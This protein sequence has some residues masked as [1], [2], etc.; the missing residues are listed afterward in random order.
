M[1]AHRIVGE[2]VARA[3]VLVFAVALPV[4]PLLPR[5]LGNG[6]GTEVEA[7]MPEDGGWQPGH[8]TAAV[9]EPL[10]LRLTSTDVVHAFAVGHMDVPPVDVNPG[11]ITDLTL[12]FDRPGTYTFYCTRW[13]GPNHWRMR[14]TIEVAGASAVAEAAEPPLYLTLGLD[15]DAPRTADVELPRK[16]SASRGASLSAMIPGRYLN[17]DYVRT[18]SPVGVWQVLRNR[19]ENTGLTDAELWDLVAWI[20]RRNTTSDALAIGEELYAQNCAAC[21]GEAGGGDGVM[22]R[23]LQTQ[24]M[25]WSD[26]AM[27]MEFGHAIEKPADFTDTDVLGASPVVLHG[28]IL[29]GGM[30]T[31]MPYWGPIFT[32]AQVWA[33]VDYLWRFQFNY[34]EEPAR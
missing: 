13:C 17:V 12:T 31:G 8:L 25:S 14:G 32:D 7:A 2:W 11:R 28:K 34:D 4:A 16:P 33:L 9:G 29:R 26:P 10:H 5:W 21:H 1:A 3:V 19:P 27:G 23:V 18:N 30:G 15:L 24:D 6:D 20:W 22:A